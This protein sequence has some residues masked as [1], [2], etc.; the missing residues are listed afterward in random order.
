MTIIGGASQVVS[1]PDV[2]LLATTATSLMSDYVN[3]ADDPW[4]G[5]PFA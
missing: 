5:S 2:V 1:D 3:L 4:V